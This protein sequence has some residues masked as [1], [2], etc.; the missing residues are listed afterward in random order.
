MPFMDRDSFITLLDKLGDADDARSLAAAREIHQR[1]Q[2]ANLKWSDLLLPMGGRDDDDADEP[3]ADGEPLDRTAE[4]ITED[5]ALI[6]RLLARSDLSQDMRDELTGMRED[7]G[8]GEFTA[9][10][11]KYLQSLEARLSRP[12]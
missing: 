11:R 8:S 5:F 7:I 1:M 12:N 3:A 10:D 4:P 9:R 2:A 6:D